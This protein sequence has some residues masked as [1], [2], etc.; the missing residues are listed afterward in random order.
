MDIS[1]QGYSIAAFVAMLFAYVYTSQTPRA[2]SLYQIF[3]LMLVGLFPCLWWLIPSRFYG[4]LVGV[5]SLLV[6]GISITRYRKA[7][8]HLSNE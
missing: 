8:K 2:S 5:V 6:I 4:V 1:G 7:K 3:P